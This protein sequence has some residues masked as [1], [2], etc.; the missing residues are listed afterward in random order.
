MIEHEA[1]P[2]GAMAWLSGAQAIA[3]ASAALFAPFSVMTMALYDA[4]IWAMALCV[5]GA[6]PLVAVAGVAANRSLP[7][8][9]FALACVP[10]ALTAA[11][12]AWLSGGALSPAAPWIFAA[13]ASA[14]F[15]GGRAGAL[16]SAGLAVA[17]GGLL[18][19]A[20]TPPVHLLGF[21]PRAHREIIAVLSWSCASFSIAAAA[22]AAIAAWSTAL[23]A[24]RHPT[25]AA[26]HALTLLFKASNICAFR[27][28]EDGHVAQVLGAEEET[29][30]VPRN[31]LRAAPLAKLTH[32]DD[33]PT[34]TRLISRAHALRGATRRNRMK[35]LRNPG[36]PPDPDLTAALR[37][38]TGLGGYRWLEATVISASDFPKPPSGLVSDRDV[39]LILRARWRPD[40]DIDMTS[41]PERAAFLAQMNSAL[42]NGVKSIVGY[43]DALKNELLG[44][45]GADG[46]R[47]FARR[48]HESGEALLELIDEIMDLAAMEAGR[49][50]GQPEMIDPVPLVDGA[51]RQVRG[52]AQQAGVAL[53]S[54]IA[55]RTPHISADRRALRRALVNVLSDAI[56]RG[57]VGDAV[58]LSVGVEEDAIRFKLVT[59]PGQ[60]RADRAEGEAFEDEM[61]EAGAVD[62]RQGES[63][64]DDPSTLG[65]TRLARM[66][67]ASLIER[68]GGTMI[69]ANGL[70]MGEQDLARHRGFEGA[71]ETVYAEALLPAPKAPSVALD[72]AEVSAGAPREAK[73]RSV[74]RRI[75]D[76]TAQEL[77]RWREAEVDED[78][79]DGGF[80][81]ESETDDLDD[82]DRPLFEPPSRKRP[83]AAE[84]A[85]RA[86]DA[87]AKE[88]A[89]PASPAPPDG[90][91]AAGDRPRKKASG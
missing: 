63:D 90:P 3:A 56:H 37:L 51:L 2:S 13:V 87:P 62:A 9:S 7:A 20:P 88:S 68:M 84:P 79:L 10:L 45:L 64:E 67:A 83:G 65:E 32:P 36:D 16:A 61:P 91:A 70:E 48:A 55:P 73:R 6:S 1:K 85:P 60:A 34:L 14:A 52:R 47:D 19:V 81:M 28:D 26:R 75:H 54:E 71:A 15:L 38:R 25:I 46:Y 24:L 31:M 41:E 44:P 69:F 59:T 27:I 49:Y 77:Q 11:L 82:V 23:P 74:E 66:V 17:I 89:L 33:Q 43:T 29:L 58:K 72:A 53:S 30:G 35:A 80:E 4:P 86:A 8:R 21:A 42:R 57:A 50:A 22:W 76:E 78:E 40:Q 39:V 18:L 5:A 12:F